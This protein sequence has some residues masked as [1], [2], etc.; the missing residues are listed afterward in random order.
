MNRLVNRLSVEQEVQ[1]LV[2]FIHQRHQKVYNWSGEPYRQASRFFK[3]IF[4]ELQY[5]KRELNKLGCPRRNFV[6]NNPNETILL[7]EIIVN[8]KN[9]GREERRLFE[10]MQS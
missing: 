1:I 4:N 3:L 6:D 9:N 2:G 7:D 10:I 8:N 5:P